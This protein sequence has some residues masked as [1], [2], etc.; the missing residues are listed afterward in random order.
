[1]SSSPSTP[2]L[3]SLSSSPSTPSLS[4]NTEASPAPYRQISSKRPPKLLLA[5]SEQVKKGDSNEEDWGV[6]DDTDFTPRS[7]SNSVASSITSDD[8]EDWDAELSGEIG[9]PLVAERTAQTDKKAKD[10]GLRMTA[11]KMMSLPLLR[12]QI[13]AFFYD[14]HRRYGTLC[15]QLNKHPLG[16]F[17]A[18]L[19]G[20]ERNRQASS[21]LVTRKNFERNIQVCQK[22][23]KEITESKGDP[24]LLLCVSKQ[25]EQFCKFREMLYKFARGFDEKV[26][27]LHLEERLEA[28][29]STVSNAEGLEIFTQIVQALHSLVDWEG[30]KSKTAARLTLQFQRYSTTLLEQHHVQ[31]DKWTKEI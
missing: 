7:H 31:Q 30:G 20:L 5:E 21:D 8:E 2:S 23:I 22:N 14:V 16:C 19:K 4:V 1:V 28:L 9:S 10:F 26:C 13:S 3:S 11:L 12:Q 6:S 29:P 17:Q 18:L 15:V 24:S 25:K 27:T